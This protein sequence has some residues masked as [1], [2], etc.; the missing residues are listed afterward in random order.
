MRFRMGL[1]ARAGS[2]WASG[3]VQQMFCIS[4]GRVRL[5]LAK[6]AHSAG[7]TGHVGDNDAVDGVRGDWFARANQNKLEKRRLSNRSNQ[8]GNRN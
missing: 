5:D 8:R 3:G 6:F 7:T 1:Y 4:D 2:T